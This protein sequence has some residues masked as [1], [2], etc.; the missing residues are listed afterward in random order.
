MHSFRI[1]YQSFLPSPCSLY[2]L[3]MDFYRLQPYGF[4]MA[5]ARLLLW[6]LAI[7]LPEA[8]EA[9]LRLVLSRVNCSSYTSG[10]P[11]PLISSQVVLPPP[12]GHPVCIISSPH[13]NRSPLTH[14][15]ALVIILVYQIIGSAKHCRTY[16]PGGPL[17][18]VRDQVTQ[19]KLS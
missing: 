10:P 18:F 6:S 7:G 13:C 12:P 1:A 3:L 2:A 16:C 8:P 17:E 19:H 9:R 14:V 11:G 15:H 5:L 4:S